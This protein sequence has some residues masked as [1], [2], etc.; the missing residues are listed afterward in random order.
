M[1]SMSTPE[2]TVCQHGYV[3]KTKLG[4]LGKEIKIYH[5]LKAHI[6]T[7]FTIDRNVLH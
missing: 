2:K 1:L 3:I 4:H 7:S 5:R 6:P